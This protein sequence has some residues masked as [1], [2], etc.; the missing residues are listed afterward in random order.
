MLEIKTKYET[1]ANEYE[2]NGDIV[3]LKLNKKD[4]TIINAKIDTVNLEKVLEK[5]NW[6]AE[7]DKDFDNYVVQNLSDYYVAGK[8]HTAKQT[9]HSFILNQHPKAPIRHI[10]G[11]T[12]DNRKSN[13]EVYTQK[14]INNY[15]NV[16][17]ETIAIILR[18]KY[19]KKIARTL[20]D[21]EDLD[22]VLNYGYAWVCFKIKGEPYA[23]ANTP[24]GRIYL[25][26]FIMDTPENMITHPINLN[27]LDNRKSNLKN[28][29]L[30]IE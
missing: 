1:T 8:K 29:P 25:N 19:G 2:I 20:I 17:S 3:Y 11:D 5:G 10:N 7:W 24:A 4:G 22:R 6:F 27:T 28:V 30:D 21:K 13:L 14:I 16:S 26:R 15:E 9:L 23:V 12:L 18:N